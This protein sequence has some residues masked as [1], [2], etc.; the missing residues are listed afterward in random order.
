MGL[1][2]NV[3]HGVEVCKELETLLRDVSGLQKFMQPIISSARTE[4]KKLEDEDG[5]YKK[6]VEKLKRRCEEMTK[7][8]KELKEAP[9]SSLAEKTKTDYEI[10]TL[11][12][13][14]EEDNLAIKENE[15]KLRKNIIKY[16]NILTHLEFVERKRFSEMKTHA[17]KYFSIKKKLSTRILEHSIQTNKRIDILDAENEFNNFIRSC[18]PN[19]V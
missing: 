6:E 11:A 19:K 1:D 14:L 9:L 12:T 15:G 13:Y 17:L 2:E 3:L 10:R 7:K 5:E 18:S 8:Q 4:Y 16:L